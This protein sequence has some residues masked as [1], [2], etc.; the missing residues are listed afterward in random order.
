MA[1]GAPVIKLAYPRTCAMCVAVLVML[2]LGR[3]LES[4]SWP[5]ALRSALIL[6][7]IVGLVQGFQWYQGSRHGSKFGQ[8][9]SR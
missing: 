5:H 9:R 3:Y 2:L 8:N 7:V 4:D 6:G 1:Y